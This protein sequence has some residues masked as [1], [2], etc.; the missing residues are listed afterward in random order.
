[1]AEVEGIIHNIIS[2]LWLPKLPKQE[3]SDYR[4][5]QKVL[6]IGAGVTKALPFNKK[7]C[8]SMLSRDFV[9]FV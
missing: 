1:M 3:P 9:D 2:G 7:P 8:N 4:M 5:A 6:G